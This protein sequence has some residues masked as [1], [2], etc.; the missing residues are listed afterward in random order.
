LF[1][2]NPYLTLSYDAGQMTDGVGA[3]LE[4]TWKIYWIAKTLNLSYTHTPIEDILWSPLDHW[5]GEVEKNSFLDEFNSKYKLP[6]DLIDSCSVTKSYEFLT[7]RSLFLNYFQSYFLKRHTLIKSVYSFDVKNKKLPYFSQLNSETSENDYLIA[8][9]IRYALPILGVS[10]WRNLG[11]EYYLELLR[12]ISNVLDRQGISYRVVV[13]TDYPKESLSIPIDSIKK[14]HQW[15]YFFTEDQVSSSRFEVESQDLK[16]LLFSEDLKVTVLYGG[17]PMEAL[18]L[19]AK[20]NYLVLSRS[21]FSA[22]GGMLN[23]EG[24][25]IQPPDFQYISSRNWFTAKQYITIQNKWRLPR[26]PRLYDALI[27]V[28]VLQ[29]VRLVRAIF[30]R[31]NQ[32]FG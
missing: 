3:Q 24:V 2:R 12:A 22:I 17:N 13:L 21:S 26:Y 6:S 27:R 20:A 15:M 9:H 7:R 1:P 32:L 8:I 16:S 28:K 14:E 25:V 18:D 23:K 11:I 31:I 29:F 30:R 19:M 10:Q 4:R 5:K